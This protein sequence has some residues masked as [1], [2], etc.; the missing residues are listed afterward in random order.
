[1]NVNKNILF[2][3]LALFLIIG[4]GNAVSSSA[5]M[6]VLGYSTIPGTVY[7]GTTAQLQLTLSNAGTDTA[8]SITI[9]YDHGANLDGT[10]MVNI[11][12]IGSG[13]TTIA[14]LPFVVPS[15]V[16]SG[17]LQLNL[18]IYYSYN[19]GDSSGTA[20]TTIAIPVSQIQ[21][22]EVRTLSNATTLAPGDKFLAQ[23]EIVN[24]GGITKNV[25]IR[26]L[27]N[28][29]FAIDG[30]SQ[31]TV[32]DVQFNSSKTISLGLRSLSSTSSG[33]YMVPLVVQ[34]QDAVQNTVSQ[35]VYVGPVSVTDVSA[36]LNIGLKPETPTEVGSQTKFELVV[37]NRGSTESSAMIEINQSSV[38]TPM[39]NSRV[40]FDHLLPGETRTQELTIGIGPSASGGYYVLPV[41]ITSDGKTYT[42]NIGVEVRAT[43][44]IMVSSRTDPTTV[45]VGSRSVTVSAQI[46]NTGNSPIRSVY[47]K[48]M[49]TT[50]F[51]TVGAT[52]KF[53]GTLNVDDF[54]TFQFVINVPNKLQPGNYN[55]PIQ[56]VF[57]D[58]T[59]TEHVINKDVPIKVSSA[60]DFGASQ[61]AGSGTG[62][63]TGATVMRR[64]GGVLFGLDWIQLLAIVVVLALGYQFGYKKYFKG[65]KGNP[66]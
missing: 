16:N 27:D 59:N 25:I 43:Q 62:I 11:G 6:Q 53:V 14:S 50:D 63:A 29:S 55:V 19:N 5:T 20:K 52:D 1:M 22:L 36:K 35:T 40:Y 64:S 23:L 15:K 10:G 2:G 21:V 37:E 65:K 66:Q 44:E 33:N 24:T 45:G 60:G 49:P 39:G 31:Y 3:L 4:F 18:N 34:Y 46:A 28:S 54:T 9:Y 38:F 12:D 26:S 7:P 47:A 13:S 57:K 8:K 58:S 17:I 41:T 51:E 56:L 30:T 42:Q 48:V 32:G 61:N